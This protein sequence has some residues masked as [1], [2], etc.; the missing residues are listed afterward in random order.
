VSGR[1]LRP[2]LD[3]FAP[4]SFYT[5]AEE[6]TLS[7]EAIASLPDRSG[8]VWLKARSPEAFLIRTRDINIPSGD[9]LD[10]VVASVRNDST[11]GDR[12]SRK[13]YECLVAERERSARPELAEDAQVTDVLAEAYRR[14]RGLSEL[15]QDEPGPA[16]GP[17][18]EP[19][20]MKGRVTK[21]R[22]AGAGGS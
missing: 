10:S 1:K 8:Y 20:P 19:K 17:S 7:L 21:P 16:N 5:A 12:V 6:R 9:A 18:D 22:R 4:P 13:E 11:L 14:T 15:K 2:S 3:P